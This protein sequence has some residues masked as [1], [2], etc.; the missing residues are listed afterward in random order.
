MG[1]VPA[2]LAALVREEVEQVVPAGVGGVC[3]L[4]GGVPIMALALSP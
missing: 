4:P 1:L 3:T 2:L